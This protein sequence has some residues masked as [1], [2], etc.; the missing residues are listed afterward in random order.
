MP[1]RY[2]PFGG[3][4][5]RWHP[6]ALPPGMAS[7]AHGCLLRSGV[8]AP[9]ALPGP[10]HAL[11]DGSVMLSEIPEADVVEFK[12]VGDADSRGRPPAVTV[13]ERRWIADPWEWL[14]LLAYDFVS[15]SDGQSYAI[16]ISR[17][18]AMP[19]TA[20]ERTEQGFSVT[21]LLFQYEYTFTHVGGYTY[22]T[23]GPYFQVGLAADP[24]RLHGGPEA[25]VILPDYLGEGA[26]RV[27]TQPIALF[28]SAGRVYGHFQ[29]I[30]VEAPD[31]AEVNGGT[32][33]PSGAP[34][35]V[36]LP[37]RLPYQEVRF[38]I[39]LNYTE[40]TRRTYHYIMTR[41][42]PP[43]APV[44]GAEL[45]DYGVEGPASEASA[46]FMV[47][48][49]ERLVL[50]T[51]RSGQAG[52]RLYRST[53]STERGFR[54][55]KEYSAD[56]FEDD[57]AVQEPTVLPPYGD[58]PGGSKTVALRNSVLHPSHFGGVLIGKTLWMSDVFRLH[59]WP[60]EFTV[61]FPEDGVGLAV[62]GNTFLVFAGEKVYAVGGGNPSHM[63]RRELSA[64]APLLNPLGL[65]RIG[66][67]VYWP[68]REG[69]AACNGGQVQIVSA[70]AFTRTEWGWFRPETMVARVADRLVL[71]ET[72]EAPPPPPEGSGD[73][74][75]LE[76]ASRVFP[77]GAAADD[78]MV[79]LCFDTESGA[80]TTYSG[81]V[82]EVASEPLVWK[83]RREWSEQRQRY[84]W[85]RVDAD[86]YPVT[87]AVSVDGVDA[88]V[89]VSIPAAGAAPLVDATDAWLPWG[90]AW[91]FQV[92]ATGTVRRIEAFERQT[93]TVGE[94]VRL[95]PETVQLLRAAWLKFEDR[96]RFCAGR[97]GCSMAGQVT[98]NFW[99]E[100]ASTPTAVDTADGR[101][102]ALPRS[103]ASA[104]GC[105]VDIATDLH[106][107]ELLLW[108]RRRVQVQGRLEVARSGDGIAPWLVSTYAFGDGRLQGLAV[109]ARQAATMRLYYDGAETPS[110]TVAVSGRTQVLL[111]EKIRDLEFDF[112]G[113][114]AEVYSVEISGGAARTVDGVVH[115]QGDG[116]LVRGLLLKFPD[117]GVWAAIC[118]GADAYPATAAL[119][120]DGAEVWSDELEDHYPVYLPRDLDEAGLWMVDVAATDT[121]WE[122]VLYPRRARASGPHVSEVRAPGALVP[123][124]GV[125]YVFERPNIPRSVLVDAEQQV[126]LRIYLD[127][128]V[129]PRYE[130]PLTPGVEHAF[131]DG[132][133]VCERLEFNFGEDDHL[134]HQVRIFGEE[135]IRVGESGVELRGRSGWRRMRLRRESAAPWRVIDIEATGTVQYRVL[136]DGVMAAQGSM[137][138]GL[139]R[140]PR[141]F[142]D[143]EVLE[144]DVW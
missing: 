110:E 130:V 40:T 4:G 142:A 76:M 6:E 129:A 27:S 26:P 127:G 9:L 3:I 1:V 2:G 13:S 85:I 77:P 67:T 28:D 83:S 71:L 123:W 69:L 55:V 58:F 82:P 50:N 12:N 37:T 112:A 35:T 125:V 111:D 64:T 32:W 51:P 139:L 48:P 10:V 128:A 57:V 93:V 115:L 36:Y 31:W 104:S 24:D 118:V 61:P 86:A 109:H 17:A 119:H 108:Q 88:G 52:V 79:N 105:R 34:V 62:T 23:K 92:T 43:M 18:Q 19:I 53:T 63:Q 73:T 106:W 49:G 56:T 72:G 22:E 87:V 95:T 103:M 114:D 60:A 39:A 136:A 54:L 42:A 133:P 21:A 80:W 101:V 102:F 116:L 96:G 135:E 65:C 89:A 16:S 137:A 7:V 138:A 99:P 41:L 120:A 8:A 107:D 131:D 74:V 98:V 124:A 78:P 91:D 134:V 94:T 75:L 33:T 90:R 81:S 20:I 141:G 144:V 45:A 47:R 132:M 29:V 97:L 38:H 46:P 122:L 66:D 113:A 126:V 143:S 100:G 5:P 30:D 117:R 15:W 44:D 140:L 84:E 121:V 14:A 59:A 11:H 25:E 68:S 70:E